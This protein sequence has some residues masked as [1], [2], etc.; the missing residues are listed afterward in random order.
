MDRSGVPV[1][2]QAIRETLLATPGVAGR[3][4]LK[5]RKSGALA[6][7]EVYTEVPGALSVGEGHDIAV[8][9]HNRVLTSHTVL[10]VIIHIDPYKPGVSQVAAY[11]EPVR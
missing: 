8:N 7:A 2:E 3:H 11:N 9:A 1:T 10:N 5:T 4:D 6:L